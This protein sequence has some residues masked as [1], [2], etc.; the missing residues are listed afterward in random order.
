MSVVCESPLDKSKIYYT[1]SFPMYFFIIL[2]QKNRSF[3]KYSSTSPL[4]SLQFSRLW[5]STWSKIRS[6]KWG[7]LL[8]IVSIV[9][10]EIWLRSVVISLLFKFWLSMAGKKNRP[11]LFWQERIQTAECELWIQNLG[12]FR[13]FDNKIVN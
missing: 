8:Q 12:F 10:S 13:Q 4:I 3:S 9:Q 6:A 5:L 2:I 7:N 11:R 1:L